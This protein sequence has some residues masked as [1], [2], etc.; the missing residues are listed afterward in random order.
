MG[1]AN[2][3]KV[4]LNIFVSLAAGFLTFLTTSFL[5]FMAI[6]VIVHSRERDGVGMVGGVGFPCLFVAMAAT[7]LVFWIRTRKKAP[8]KN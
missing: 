1:R 2:T 6:R 4:A 5:A 3:M 7:C 8:Q